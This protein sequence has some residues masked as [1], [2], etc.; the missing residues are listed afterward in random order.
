MMRS[1]LVSALSAAVVMAALSP[2][3]A[4]EGPENSST[5]SFTDSFY[6]TLTITPQTVAV[7][8]SNFQ[9]RVIGR[10]NTGSILFDDSFAD[11][12]TSSVV[13]DALDDA[14]AAIIAAA[15]PAVVI[16]DPVRISSQSLS[17]VS[18][19]VVDTLTGTT[20]LAPTTIVVFGPAPIFIGDLGVC[21]TPASGSQPPSGCSLT[22]TPYAVGDDETNFNTFRHDNDQIQRTTTN[23]TTTTLN[24]TYEV[25]GVVAPIG[26]VNGALVREAGLSGER[27]LKRL[28]TGPDGFPRS[29]EGDGETIFDRIWLEAYGTWGSLDGTGVFTPGYDVDVTGLSAGIGREV[30]S[31]VTVSLGVDISRADADMILPG[32]FPESGEVDMTQ[33]GL[34]LNKDW[35]PVDTSVAATLGFG[36]FETVSGSASLGGVSRA[37]TDAHLWGVEGRVSAPKALGGGKLTPFGGITIVNAKFDSVTGTGPFALTV[38]GDTHTSVQAFAGLGFDHVFRLGQNDLTLKLAASVRHELGDEKILLNA[39]F[40][41]GSAMPVALAESGRT[42]GEIEA[43]LSYAFSETV[44]AYAGYEGR[45]ADGA[46]IHQA[47]VGLK[48]RF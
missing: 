2:A 31:G 29:P 22:G 8:Q 41:G 43:G 26:T 20:Q 30:D 36:T 11:A 21:T 17:S 37:K 35:G 40:A 27:F 42:S 14:R 34:S 15:G 7:T 47:K 3:S 13:Q 23:T 4:Q 12:F 44:S 10:L 1:V 45:I 28:T 33:V 9:T 39:S 46:D 18:S 32:A 48:I 5:D 25:V 38:S 6:R 16:L 19:A 24:E